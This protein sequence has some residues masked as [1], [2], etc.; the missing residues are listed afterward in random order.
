MN[1]LSNDSEM[2]KKLDEVFL[3]HKGLTPHTENSVK[4]VLAHLFA[5][6]LQLAVLEARKEQL[7]KV[8]VMLNAY[9]NGTSTFPAA[10]GLLEIRD[11]ITAL[12]KQIEGLK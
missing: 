6:Q 11:H 1:P 7:T 9:I 2:R 3:H 12:N 8:Q 10:D 5:S 4:A